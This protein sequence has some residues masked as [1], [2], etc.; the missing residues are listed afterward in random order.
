M[1]RANEKKMDFPYKNALNEFWSHFEFICRSVRAVL[2]Q[3]AA[4]LVRLHSSL[5]FGM[6]SRRDRDASIGG[7]TTAWPFNFVVRRSEQYTYTCTVQL[8]VAQRPAVRT[9]FVARPPFFYWPRENVEI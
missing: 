2:I 7:A 8:Q 9:F 3:R 1:E 5:E 6:F 4:I